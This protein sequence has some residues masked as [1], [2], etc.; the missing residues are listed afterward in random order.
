MPP[1]NER[2]QFGTFAGS[3]R[4]VRNWNDSLVHGTFKKHLLL[5]LYIA[6]SI[7]VSY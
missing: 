4:F 3:H 2:S 5:P 1:D 7:Y 6:R